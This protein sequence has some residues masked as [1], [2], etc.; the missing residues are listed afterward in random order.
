M[1]LLHAGTQPVQVMQV[2]FPRWHLIL[3]WDG[4]SSQ[5]ME[6]LPMHRVPT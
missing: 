5:Q 6:D 2:Q 3:T 1:M 4:G